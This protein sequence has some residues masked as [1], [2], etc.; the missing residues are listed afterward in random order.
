MLDMLDSSYLYTPVKVSPIGVTLMSYLM[1]SWL[2]DAELPV[3]QS[4]ESTKDFLS[5]IHDTE[6]RLVNP[7]AGGILSK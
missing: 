4:L 3:H 2:W 6:T 1:L 7:I 5:N